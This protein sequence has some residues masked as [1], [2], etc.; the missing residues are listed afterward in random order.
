LTTSIQVK[1]KAGIIYPYLCVQTGSGVY[2]ASYPMDIEGP[3]P[4]IKAAGA[5]SCG[6]FKKTIF[7]SIPENVFMERRLSVS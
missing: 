7:T 5:K 2:P 1:A 6:E 3:F 4:G